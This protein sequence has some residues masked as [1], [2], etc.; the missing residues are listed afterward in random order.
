MS[1]DW[2]RT[3]K[4]FR[5]GLDA[6]SDAFFQGLAHGSLSVELF[7]PRGRDVQTPHAQDELYII[8][9][10]HARLDKSGEVIDVAPGDVIMVEAGVDHRFV[11]F[12]EDF[13]VWVVFFGPVGGEGKQYADRRDQALRSR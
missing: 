7:E 5:R 12:S 13:S 1:N 10:G 11:T 3:Y 6:T 9:E 8:R 4:H 2:H